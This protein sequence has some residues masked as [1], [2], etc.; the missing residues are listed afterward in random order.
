MPKW[1]PTVWIKEGKEWVVSVVGGGAGRNERGGG[2]GGGE[3]VEVRWVK[4]KEL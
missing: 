4:G 3:E 2:G 1:P